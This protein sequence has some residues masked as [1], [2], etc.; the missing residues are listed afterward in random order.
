MITILP[1]DFSKP[2]DQDAFW[3]LL[4]AYAIDIMGGGTPLD[5]SIRTRLLHDL[6]Q[7]KQ[8]L[9]YIAYDTNIPVGLVNCFLSY[10]TFYAAPLLNIHDLV[11]LPSHRGKGISKLLLKTVEDKAVELGCCKLTLEVL[12]G[13]QVA[14]KVYNR[15]GFQSYELDPAAGKALFLEKLLGA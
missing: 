4:N 2:S 15:F 14:R 11:V 9:N 5:A 6:S 1:V 13:N 12:E 3:N 7:N 10:S 8:A